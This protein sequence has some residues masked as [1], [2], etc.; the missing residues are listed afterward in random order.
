[1]KRKTLTIE[2]RADD[3]VL[4][5]STRVEFSRP[6]RDFVEQAIRKAIRAAVRAGLVRPRPANKS[7][8]KEY[9][10]QRFY[11]CDFCKKMRPGVTETRFGDVCRTCSTETGQ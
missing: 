2:K 9:A 5:W 1:M 6:L 4:A 8:R 10:N 3:C 7:V 11:W